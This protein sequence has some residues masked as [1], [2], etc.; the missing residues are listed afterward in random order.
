ML[1]QKDGKLNGVMKR[2]CPICKKVIDAATRKRSRQEKFFP[3]CSV[4]CKWIDLGHWLD[5]DY[6]IVSKPDA[7]DQESKTVDKPDVKADNN[8]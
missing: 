6:K 7:V 1:R 2:T 4:R 3:F 8:T 5:G